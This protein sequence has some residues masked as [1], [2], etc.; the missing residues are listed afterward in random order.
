MPSSSRRSL[1]RK[2][3][4]NL[5]SKIR[6]EF[7][8]QLTGCLES[9]R[10]EKELVR[11]VKQSYTPLS[12]YF[13]RFGV[14]LQMNAHSLDTIFKRDEG[15]QRFIRLMKA[16]RGQRG[17]RKSGT[18]RRLAI[19]MGG[20]YPSIRSFFTAALAAAAVALAGVRSIQIVQGGEGSNIATEAG[21]SA[22]GVLGAIIGSVPGVSHVGAAV[23][24]LFS[25]VDLRKESGLPERF[26]TANDVVYMGAFPPGKDEANANATREAHDLMEGLIPVIN[27]NV[28]FPIQDEKGD[29]M[30]LQPFK[31]VDGYETT[32]KEYIPALESNITESRKEVEKLR[33]QFTGQ[34][35]QEGSAREAAAAA[36][37]KLLSGVRTLA[38]K[39]G[40]VDAPL[41]ATDAEARIAA[42]ESHIPRAE[43]NLGFVTG[44]RNI[45]SKIP[46]S[47]VGFHT[48]LPGPVGQQLN[49]TLILDIR[50]I[51]LDIESLS[52]DIITVSDPAVESIQKRATALLQT[53]MALSSVRSQP[54][55]YKHILQEFLR[56]N[57]ASA[58]YQR[59]A[60]NTLYRMVEAE[61]RLEQNLSNRII[62]F[63]D[64]LLQQ[65]DRQAKT[66][67]IDMEKDGRREIVNKMLESMNQYQLIPKGS[68]H[69]FSSRIITMLAHPGGITYAKESVLQSYA[70]RL[71]RTKVDTVG[72]VAFEILQILILSGAAIGFALSRFPEEKK[73]ISMAE[74]RLLLA[75]T[76]TAVAQA[77]AT[78]VAGNRQML[79]DT[80]VAAA[81]Q[82]TRL[83]GDQQRVSRNGNGNRVYRL[84][85][86]TTRR[87]GSR[88]RGQGAAPMLGNAT[89]TP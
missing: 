40:Y 44:E 77:T 5:K 76:A 24:G 8:P 9:F 65:I 36:L 75:D 42:L 1:T 79:M 19:Q 86:T 25:A 78:A 43:A 15:L 80:A 6:S 53:A 32:F 27:W 54:E 12:I 3:G 49:E 82:A 74:H 81:T 50:D 4:A 28:T 84:A 14:T 55:G 56:G 23:S 57:F 58:L 21:K 63:H 34:Q 61:N 29:V 26:L 67:G 88:E 46:G 39:T 45:Y 38:S 83:L 13:R 70:D 64:R 60:R 16:L 73:G 11:W 35:G 7:L 37:A 52:H 20:E 47:G 17:Q 10:T 85:N 48:I 66:R 68:I 59:L 72:L 51:A 89:P 87:S 69:E 30:V 33:K 31:T 2:R 71:Q 22:A 62:N 41:S 18:R